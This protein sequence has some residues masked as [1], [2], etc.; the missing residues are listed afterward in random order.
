MATP[1]VAMVNCTET[2]GNPQTPNSPRIGFTDSG[3]PT[4]GIW[5]TGDRLENI[6]WAGTTVSPHAYVCIAGGVPGTWKG[7]SKA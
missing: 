4:T 5:Y 6:A 7:V 2:Q 3:A 1:A